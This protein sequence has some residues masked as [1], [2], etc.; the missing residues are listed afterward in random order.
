MTLRER[1]DRWFLELW[2]RRNGAIIDEMI[3]PEC[4]THG[5]PG[6]SHGPEGLRVFYELFCRAFSRI[7]VRIEDSVELGDRIGFR[8]TMTVLA[9]DG[10]AHEFSGGGMA[11]FRDGRFI[12]AWNA[13][14]NLALLTSMGLVPHGAFVNA[15][16]A[17]AKLV[18]S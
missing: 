7:E 3:D 16:L 13:F 17:Q 10:T 8:C 15:L 1:L 9:R 4:T 11:R 12:E 5:V 2:V 14:D 6:M 18:A